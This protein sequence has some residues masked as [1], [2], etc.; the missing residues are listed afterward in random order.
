MSVFVVGASS[1]LAPVLA[2]GMF[3]F[4]VQLVFPLV[5]IISLFVAVSS[6]DSSHV[7]GGF[8]KKIEGANSDTTDAKYAYTFKQLEDIV[9]QGEWLFPSSIS[10][11]ISTGIALESHEEFLNQEDRHRF[12]VMKKDFLLLVESY[13]FLNDA[14]RKETE[15]E[16]VSSCERIGVTC[17]DLL[18]S[19][20]NTNKARFDKQ[21]MV[22]KE[23]NTTETVN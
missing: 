15:A 6:L 12:A 17:S 14:D 5:V 21:V 16:F 2:D 8:A 7:V 11:V 9:A 22:V 18:A 19:I 23:R 4:I 10:D 20:S 3:P 13:L 1:I